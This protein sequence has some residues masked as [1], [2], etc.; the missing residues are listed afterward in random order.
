MVSMEWKLRVTVRQACSVECP[1][2]DF[3]F[4]GSFDASCLHMF[5]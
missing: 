4:S 1:D 2:V 5:V 3:T